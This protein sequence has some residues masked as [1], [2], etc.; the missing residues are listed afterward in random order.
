MFASIETKGASHIIIHIPHEGA[1]KSLPA[2]AR[3]LE[4]NAV[5]VNRGYQES[6]VIKP[7]MSIILGD[8]FKNENSDSIIIIQ[9]N[10]SVID[11][12]FVNYTPD[13]LISNA[14]AMRREKDENTRV[15]TE[16]QFVKQQLATAKEQLAALTAIE[17]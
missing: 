2:L 4:Q 11:P 12:D 6:T 14:K 1:D 7:E 8:E 5:F 15:R 3:M 10:N 13:V 17:E 9:T 16:L